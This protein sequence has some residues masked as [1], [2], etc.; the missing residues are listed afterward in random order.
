[1]DIIDTSLNLQQMCGQ[2]LA[3]FPS[4]VLLEDI[5]PFTMLMATSHQTR[6]LPT[7]IT[8]CQPVDQVCQDSGTRVIRRLA[9]LPGIFNYLLLSK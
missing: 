6:R 9:I 5:L 7:A 3:L 8:L 1:M 2:P 4:S